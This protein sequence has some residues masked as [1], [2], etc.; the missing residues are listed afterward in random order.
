MK[1][2]S[3]HTVFYNGYK[4]NKVDN[5]V[6]N[7]LLELVI[8]LWIACKHYVAHRHPFG[9]RRNIMD[10]EV[11]V[12]LDEMRSQHTVYYNGYEATPFKNMAAM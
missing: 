6:Y 11:Y 3:P 10:H 5:V 4:V 9:S 1:C 8:R 2:S 7:H 12:L